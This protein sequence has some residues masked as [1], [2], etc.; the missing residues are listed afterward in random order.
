M[1]VNQSIQ[2]KGRREYVLL[3]T[4]PSYLHQFQ[5]LFSPFGQLK[6]SESSDELFYETGHMEE[7]VDSK[8]HHWSWIVAQTSHDLMASLLCNDM[9]LPCVIYLYFNA[10]D[11]CCAEHL[12]FHSW[13]DDGCF[14]GHASAVPCV[15]KLFIFQKYLLCSI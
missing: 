11:R 8:R 14:P 12:L 3:C 1:Q 10:G 15:V 9:K 5:Y 2:C 13:Q 6:T 7:I 4:C